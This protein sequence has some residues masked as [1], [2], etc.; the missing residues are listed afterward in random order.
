[1]ADA[2]GP[3]DF[4]GGQLLIPLRAPTDSEAS[5]VDAEELASLTG[6][7]EATQA[8]LAGTIRD[9]A[10]RVIRQVA[11]RLPSRPFFS[12]SN[13]QI[14]VIKGTL[15]ANGLSMDRVD[16]KPLQVSYVIC[17]SAEHVTVSEP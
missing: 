14:L 16:G 11:C 2:E 8:L 5:R 17:S 6:S 4:G 12:V 9:D 13:R 7:V 3:Q 1:M 10:E 15:L